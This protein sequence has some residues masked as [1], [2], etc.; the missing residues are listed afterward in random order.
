MKFAHRIYSERYDGE[1]VALADL[2]NL[3]GTVTP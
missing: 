2:E 1:L 3:T